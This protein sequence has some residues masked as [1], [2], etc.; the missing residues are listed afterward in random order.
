VK[1]IVKR[2]L[3]LL[4]VALVVVAMLVV[5]ASPGFA[6]ITQTNRGG[7]DP[8]GVANGIPHTNPAGKCPPGQN[9]PQQERK[10]NR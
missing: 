6:K 3:M 5:M 10:C 7:N 4:T 8:G 2:I 1:E 9:T